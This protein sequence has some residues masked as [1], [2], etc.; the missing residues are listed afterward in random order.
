MIRHLVNRIAR[1]LVVAIFAYTGF[2]GIQ[3]VNASFNDQETSTNNSLQ[4]VSSWYDLDWYWRRPVIITNSGGTLM[5]CQVLVTLDTAA[6]VTAGKMKSDGSDIRFA[7]SDGYTNLSYWIESG[8][9]TASTSIWVK[10]PSIPSGNSNV[11][12]YY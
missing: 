1:L 10:V 12:I 8:M 9:N 5:D 11:Y 7:G 4:V 6:L 2:T 3:A